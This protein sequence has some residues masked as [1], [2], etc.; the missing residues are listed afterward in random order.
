MLA[1]LASA[2]QETTERVSVDNAGN[3]SNGSSTDASISADGHYVAFASNASNLVPAD[4]NGTADVFVHDR[5]AES[6]ERVSLGEGGTEA[7]GPSETAS[8]R[9]TAISDDGRW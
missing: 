5:Q 9:H 8:L 1:S 3:L 6:T 4:N 2:S 7:N